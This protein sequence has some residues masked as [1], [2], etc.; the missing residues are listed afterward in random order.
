LAA[1][2]A[3][4]TVGAARP[5]RAFDPA[6]APPAAGD[7]GALTAGTGPRHDHWQ[8]T[9]GRPFVSA[10]FDIGIIY[11]RPA[12]QLGY[13]EPHYRW[14]GLETYAGFATFGA[15]EYVGLRGVVPFL[16]ARVGLRYQLPFDQFYL[17]PQPFYTRDDTELELH[18]RSSYSALETELSATAPM[19]GGRLIA[20]ATGYTVLGVPADLHLFEEALKVVIEPPVLW[21]ARLGYLASLGWGELE[22]DTLRLGAAAEVIHNPGREAVTVRVGPLVSVALTC[23]LEAVGAA[24]IAVTSPDQLGLLGADFGT[25]GLRYRW[26]TGD[27]RPALP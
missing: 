14:F 1:S 8:G 12:L 13:G 7:R 5:A 23:H 2:V 4:A 22:P 6:D 9:P 10:Q 26:A 15:A 11:G 24:M 27:P 20:V 16:D 19:P 17:T 3:L 25:L 18:G 21:R